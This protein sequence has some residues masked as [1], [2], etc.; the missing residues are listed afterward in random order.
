MNNFFKIFFL[1]IISFLG[2]NCGTNEDEPFVATPTRDEATQYAAD[3]LAIETFLKTHSITVDASFGVTA[4]P[5][6]TNLDPTSIWGSNNTTPKSTLLKR[7][8]LNNG[9]NYTLYYLKLNQGGGDYACDVDDIQVNYSGRLIPD[10]SGVAPAPFD[11]SEFKPTFSFDINK[12]NYVIYGWSRIIP[13]FNCAS[14]SAGTDCGA[15]VMFI[16]SRFAYFDRART[17]I[18]EYSP[19]IFS[20]KLFSV[21]H[22]DFDGD[23]I[24]SVNEDLDGDHY[25]TADNSDGDTKPNYADFDD[26]NDNVYTSFE[27]KRPKVLINGVLVDNGS[28]PFS[29]SATDDPLTLYVDESQGVPSCSNDFTSPTRVRRYLDASCK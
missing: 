8:V 14:N 1:L 10:V 4:Y 7:E 28:Y 17:G 6:V 15:G 3:N 18:P 19:L 2:S 24:L 25:V 9:V 29:G 23:G 27:I 26:D 20:F 16:P 11:S 5:I 12:S 21:A 13:Q 22:Y